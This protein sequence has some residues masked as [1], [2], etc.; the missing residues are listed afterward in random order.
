[1]QL[2]EITDN[3]D[4]QKE[5]QDQDDIEYQQDR[6]IIGNAGSILKQVNFK[7]GEAQQGQED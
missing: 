2:D 3:Q 4:D 6:D 7:Y 5:Q 1:M